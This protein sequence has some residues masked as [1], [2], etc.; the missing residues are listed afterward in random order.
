[1]NAETAQQERAAEY[2]RLL[3]EKEELEKETAAMENI[4]NK[5]HMEAREVWP[6]P[7]SLFF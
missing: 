6:L 2:A 5:R 4:L 3:A 7:L 1:M